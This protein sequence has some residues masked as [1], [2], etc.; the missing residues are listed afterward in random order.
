MCRYVETLT[1][2]FTRSLPL[3]VLTPLRRLNEALIDF[4]LGG[5]GASM[6]Q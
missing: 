1:V 5:H 2:D 6:S 3:P 4:F